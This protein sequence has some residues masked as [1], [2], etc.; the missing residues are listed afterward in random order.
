MPDLSW[1]PQRSPVL[2]ARNPK[3]QKTSKDPLQP[4]APGSDSCCSSRAWAPDIWLGFR[5]Q[6]RMTKAG[7]GCLHSLSS[8]SQETQ[9]LRSVTLGRFP[10]CWNLQRVDHETWWTIAFLDF[11]WTLWNLWSLS[12]DPGAAPRSCV[13][14]SHVILNAPPKRVQRTLSSVSLNSSPDPCLAVLGTTHCLDHFL[15][16]PLDP[17]LDV[18]RV[19]IEKMVIISSPRPASCPQWTLSVSAWPSDP[20]M[21]PFHCPWPPRIRQR[22]VPRPSTCALWSLGSGEL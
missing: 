8:A 14:G 18:F 4:K 11:R 21:S 5:D 17:C 2:D 7:S 19:V 16:A 12:A 6:R 13:S 22:S 9:S 10:I 3:T 15:S 20:S 1:S